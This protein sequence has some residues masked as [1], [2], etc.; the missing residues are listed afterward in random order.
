WFDAGRVGRLATP[1]PDFAVLAQDAVH[2]GDRTHV[3][4]LVE[5]LVIHHRRR[6]VDVLFAVEQRPHLVTLLRRERPRLR[7]RL[8]GRPGRL[9]ALAVPAVVVSLWPAGGPARR[10][11]PDQRGQLRDR[12]VDHLLHRLGHLVSPPGCWWRAGPAARRAF[13]ARR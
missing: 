13:P 10:P 1:F 4:T 11:H 8:A 2:R 7:D 6:L 12:L 5:Q 3:D 9:R